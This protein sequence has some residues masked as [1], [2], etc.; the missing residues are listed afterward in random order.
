MRKEGHLRA[1]S[2]ARSQRRSRTPRRSLLHTTAPPLLCPT[3]PDPIVAWSRR[4][5]DRLS[6][7]DSMA[8]DPQQSVEKATQ[9]HFPAKSS[10]GGEGDVVPQLAGRCITRECHRVRIH[11]TDHS[12][13]ASSCGLG[14]ARRDQA[15]RKTEF[16]VFGQDDQLRPEVVFRGRTVEYAEPGRLRW[17]ARLD[18]ESQLVDRTLET[19]PQKCLVREGVGRVRPDCIDEVIEIPL[20]GNSHIIAGCF[21]DEAGRLPRWRGNV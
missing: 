7:V 16:P 8:P 20:S 9:A 1:Q 21:P 14:C 3:I 12:A 6:C 4:A 5:H 18:D 17:T 19:A 11:H 10:R 2:S 15:P 13:G